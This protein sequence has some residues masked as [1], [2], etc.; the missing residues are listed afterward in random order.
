LCRTEVIRWKSSDSADIEGLL[1][2]PTRYEQGKHYPLLVIVHT[3]GGS[4]LTVFPANQFDQLSS[5]F[6]P[7]AVFS[8]HGY[9]VLQCNNRGGGLPGYGPSYSLPV[10]KPKEK[11]YQD[12]MSG[13]DYAIKMG[14]ADDTRLGIMGWSNGGLVTSWVISQ[15][16]RFK[17]AVIGAGFPDLISEASVNPLIP[18]DLGAEF[19]KDINPYLEHSAIFHIKDASTPTLILHGEQDNA[20]PIGQAYELHNALKQQGIPVKMVVYPRGGHVPQEPKQVLDIAKRHLEWFDQ[21]LHP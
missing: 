7:P 11:A 12:L 16:A 5:G 21:Y 2:Y 15:T 20:V 1:T 6:Y 13:V 18:I 9:A 4:F 10:F 14:V 8:A 19:W 17:A 3:G